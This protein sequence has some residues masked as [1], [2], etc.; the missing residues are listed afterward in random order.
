[1]SHQGDLY[2]RTSFWQADRW[3]DLIALVE[4]SPLR[5]GDVAQ[6]LDVGCGSGKQTKALL[7][8]FPHLEH[9]DAVDVS[10]PMLETARRENADPKIAYKELGAEKIGNLGKVYDVVCANFVLHWV[11]NKTATMEGLNKI[12]RKDSYLMIGTC[13]DLP[14][15][16]WDV[17]A[18]MRR[19][20]KVGAD[21]AAPF[22]YLDLVGWGNLLQQYGWR[23]EAAHV[24]HDDH[25]ASNAREYLEHWVAA[26]TQK[27]CY[28]NWY[29]D[30]SDNQKN[31]MLKEILAKYRYHDEKDKDGQS[32]LLFKE[33]TLL[34]VARRIA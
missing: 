6:V 25:Y 7:S 5:M 31:L 21:V 34:L 9:V 3:E 16:L 33:E 30:L 20:F 10:T 29:D 24:K 2:N 23:I 32:A 11:E 22:H 17:D 1:M 15:I 26:S 12:T 28:G 19:E 4:D 18:F 27:I 8:A 13:Q 14:Q